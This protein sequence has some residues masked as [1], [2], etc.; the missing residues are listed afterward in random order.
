MIQH[1]VQYF[2]L[3]LTSFGVNCNLK[4]KLVNGF[5]VKFVCLTFSL[6]AF[7]LYMNI[8]N[9]LKVDSYCSF[10]VS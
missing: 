6:N 5:P 2:I 7:V 4:Q 8:C 9:Q 1:S 3:Q 10:A